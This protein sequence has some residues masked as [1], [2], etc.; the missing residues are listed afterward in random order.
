[1]KKLFIICCVGLALTAC[2]SEEDIVYN[3]FYNMQ[4]CN[5]DKS[6]SCTAW[7]AEKVAYL[8]R[9][10]Q[11]SACAYLIKQGQGCFVSSY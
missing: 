4:H 10:N 11:L 1:M 2:Q 8:K 3:Y 7:V 5:T 9:T 6:S